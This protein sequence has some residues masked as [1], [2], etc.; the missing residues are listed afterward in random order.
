M[1]S[2]IQAQ[3]TQIKADAYT[4]LEKALCDQKATLT[5]TVTNGGKEALLEAVLITYR[6]FDE[7]LTEIDDLILKHVKSKLSNEYKGT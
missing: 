5:A 4:K 7:T 6:N 2:D 1:L 3:I